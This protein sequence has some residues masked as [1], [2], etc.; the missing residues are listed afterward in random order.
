MVALFPSELIKFQSKFLAFV[1]GVSTP[2]LVQASS[3]KIQT[4]LM[5]SKINF[6]HQ[7]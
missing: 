5:Y 4:A 7:L 2:P 3:E 1:N 6:D